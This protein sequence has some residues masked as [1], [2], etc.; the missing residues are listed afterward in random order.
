MVFR[1]ITLSFVFLVGC[2]SAQT[3]ST[4]HSEAVGRDVE[5]RTTSA[6]AATTRPASVPGVFILKNVVAS[7]ATQDARRRA[8]KTLTDD[9][10]AI[11]E[12]DYANDP[13]A[14]VDALL[15]DLLKIRSDIKEKKLLLDPSIDINRLWI[16]PE[17]FAL[18]RDVTFYA[19][20]QKTWQLDIAYPMDAKAPA[21]T[22]MEITCDNAARMGNFSLV[23]CHDTLV[24]G[25][26]LRGFAAA[27]IDHPVPAPYKGLDDP[28]PELIYRLKSAVRTLRAQANDLGLNGKIGAVGFSRGGPM[29]AFL[30][31]TNGR[32][33]FDV[34]GEHAGVSSDVQAALVHGNRYDYS[35]LSD[36]DPML[37]RF[38]KAWGG[39]ET[40]RERWLAHG[41]AHYLVERAA[42]MYLNTSDTESAEY[43]EGL[44]ALHEKLLTLGL[45]HEFAVDTDGR[46]HAVSTDAARLQSIYGFLARHLER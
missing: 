46:G 20:D 3:P 17:G 22:L 25:A 38:A 44:R 35:K 18:K 23:F 6:Q 5:L 36:A 8:A 13:A 16:L 27:M 24:E 33:E 12:I 31:V 39:R 10:N 4:W 32:A 43:R 28:M 19:N 9:G 21:P 7:T 26:L 2:V 34:G 15:K 1:V 45:D 37:E 29:A 11:V 14:T 30:A 40:N 41:A 42:P